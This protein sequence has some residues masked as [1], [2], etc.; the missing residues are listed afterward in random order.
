MGKEA[1]SFR[2]GPMPRSGRLSS[3]VRLRFS[4]TA[5]PTVPVKPPA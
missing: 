2:I 4:C 1:R 3:T 5:Q